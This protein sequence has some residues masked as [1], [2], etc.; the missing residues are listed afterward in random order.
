MTTFPV[1]VTYPEP[2]LLRT[3]FPYGVTYPFET[4]V[5]TFE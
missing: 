3:T 4:G 2:P 5:Y 1:G